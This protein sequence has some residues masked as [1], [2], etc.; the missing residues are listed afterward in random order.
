MIPTLNRLT[1]LLAGHRTLTLAVLAVIVTG[2]HQYRPD[3]I[4]EVVYFHILALLGFGSSVT[5]RMAIANMLKELTAQLGQSPETPAIP[6]PPSS[7]PP[8]TL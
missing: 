7:P 1:S 2:V 6:P 4:S 3:W 5:L 8:P